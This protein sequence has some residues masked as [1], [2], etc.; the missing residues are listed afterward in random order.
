MDKQL[1]LCMQCGN[2]KAFTSVIGLSEDSGWG[3]EKEPMCDRCKGTG[4]MK[5]Y[6]IED[7]MNNIRV[8]HTDKIGKWH[9]D[10]IP[11]EQRIDKNKLTMIDNL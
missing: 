1:S 11:K 6:Y 8:L 3:F 7:K 5:I 9:E 10:I 4:C 2:A